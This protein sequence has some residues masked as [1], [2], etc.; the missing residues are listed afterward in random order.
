MKEFKQEYKEKIYAGVLGKII[1]VYLGIPVE[2]WEYEKIKETYGEIYTYVQPRNNQTLIVADDDISGMFGFFKTV[3]DNDYDFSITAKDIGD[4]WLNYI[5]ENRTVLWWG[6]IGNSVEHTAYEN[7]KRG[8]HAPESGSLKRNG[9]V[10]ANQ[11][12]AQIFMDAYAMMCAG[13]PDKAVWY[14]GQ[15]ARVSHDDLAANAAEFL[16][17]LEAMAFDERDLDKL[18]NYCTR[19]VRFPALEKL[20]GDVRNLTAREKD[21]RRMRDWMNE[22]YGYHLYPGSCHI[23]P[24][25]GMVLTAIL[26]GGDDFARSLMIATSAG[27]DTDC[28]AA[29]VG[30]FNGIRLGLKGIEEGPDLRGAVEDRVYVVTSDGGAGVSDAVLESRKII[31]AAQLLKNCPADVETKR[32]AFDFPGSVQGFTKCPAFPYENCNVRLQNHGNGLEIC[33]DGLAI[34]QSARISTP[35]FL[36]PTEH[37]NRETVASPTLYEGQTVSFQLDMEKDSGVS[38]LP[39]IRYADAWDKQ[40]TVYGPENVLHKGENRI[41]WKIPSVDGMPICRA[42]LEFRSVRRFNGVIT[43]RWMD[44][45][46]APECFAQK[47]ILM[48]TIWDTKPFWASAFVSGAQNFTPN[49]SHTYCIANNDGSALATIGTRDFKD[50][51]MTARVSFSLHRG[52]GIVV[53]SNGHRRYYAAIVENGDS[54]SIIKRRDDT[55]TVLATARVDYEQFTH[56][57]LR[58]EARGSSLK[59]QFGNTVLCAEDKEK[60]YTCGGAGFIIDTGTMFIDGFQIESC[61]EKK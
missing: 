59:A 29:N 22:H 25:H 49:L 10:M 58:L 42:G 56:Y 4:T 43:L 24:N 38:V 54:L 39:Y 19:Y 34:G 47:G 15:C 17:A 16:A 48:K 5:F 8:I 31:K 26:A 30:C 44:W 9:P 40:H 37:C 3:E 41:Q 55:V 18:F 7:L 11:I 13:D 50:Y 23:M 14:A 2:G 27:W 12:G 6:G 57:T 51:S 20:I 53:R 21:W 60:P 52:A 46:G 32:F 36:D 45:Q 61:G 35:T 33:L 28:N 1:G